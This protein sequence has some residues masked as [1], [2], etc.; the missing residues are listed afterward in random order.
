LQKAQLLGRYDH[1]LDEKGRLILPAKLRSMFGTSAFLAR[2]N[3]GCIA[4]WRQEEFQ[5]ELIKKQSM[6]SG[7][8]N[9]RNLVRAWSASVAEQVIDKQWRI[10]IPQELRQYADLRSDVVVIGVIDHVELWA[11]SSWDGQV[12]A[13]EGSVL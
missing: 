3:E 5:E 2:Y 6:L 13:L 9:D 10:L 4:L 1:C 7:D 8:A 11:P 12:G